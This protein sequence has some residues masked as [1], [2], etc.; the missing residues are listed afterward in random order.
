MGVSGGFHKWTR[1]VSW[2]GTHNS[3]P[4]PAKFRGWAA[5]KPV[6][7]SLEGMWGAKPLHNPPIFLREPHPT[8]PALV[9]LK[10]LA[11]PSLHGDE[12]SHKQNFPYSGVIKVFSKV[13]KA[14]DSQTN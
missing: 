10:R 5:L 11:E 1:V 6:N 9:E 13:C 3:I 14:I 8:P 2:G 4:N 7:L 12:S